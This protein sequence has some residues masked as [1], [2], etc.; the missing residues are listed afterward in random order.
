MVCQSPI[1]ELHD[2]NQLADVLAEESDPAATQQYPNAP[3]VPRLH[4]IIMKLPW[5]YCA[6]ND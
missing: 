6:A 3:V 1:I 5:L 2:L 4:G